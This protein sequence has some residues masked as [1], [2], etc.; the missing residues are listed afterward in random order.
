MTAILGDC[1]NF[2]PLLS[3]NTFDSCVTDPPYEIGLMGRKWDRSGVSFD[4][5]TWAAVM[6]VLKPGAWLLAFSSPRTYHR[7]ACAIEDGGFEVHNMLMWLYGSGMNKVG[8]RE[9]P[10]WPGAGGSLKP[11]HEPIV[12]ARKPLDG[13][14]QENCAKWGTGC[15]EIDGCRVPLLDEAD[16]QAFAYNH[17]VTERLPA[18]AGGKPTGM[19]EGGWKQRVGASSTPSG[20]W[21]AN[22]LH[23]GEAGLLA[24]SR[25]FFCAKATRAEKGDGNTHETVKPLALMNYGIKLVTPP[26]GAVLDPFC[27]S[28]ST[29]VEAKRLSH[30]CMGVDTDPKAVEISNR[31][32]N[33]ASN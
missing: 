15:V 33:N 30:P 2:L 31:R 28:G 21:P 29:L 3:E 1:R 32:L 26:G 13:T 20:R 7:I 14:L 9:A 19:L 25:F 5:A 11:G 4:P 23:D 16:A 12:M 18:E 22:V 10:G 17:A 24:A 27:G 8:Y 6:R